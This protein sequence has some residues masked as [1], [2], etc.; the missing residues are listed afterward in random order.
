V[1]D[2]Q[3]KRILVMFCG[4][5]LTMVHRPDGSYGTPD[6]P[7]RAMR[8]I[9]DLEPRLPDEVAR[10]EARFVANIDSTNVEPDHWVKMIGTIADSYEDYDGFVITHG[11]DTMAYTASALSVAIADLGKP[12]VITGAQI[13]SER[14]DSDAQRN[15]VNAV[16]VA[17]LDLAGV[18]LVF[19][20]EII[21][22]RKATKVSES[23]LNAFETVN[24]RVFGEIRTDIRFTGPV[25]ARH[26]RRPDFRPTFDPAV[27]VA[28]IVP[29]FLPGQISALIACGA[30][31]I[32]VRG[33][34]VGNVPTRLL[35]EIEAAIGGG[36]PVVV[37]TQCVEGST[38]MEVYEVGRSVLT[39]GAIQ[40]RDFS[41]EY[42]V[43]RAMWVLGQGRIPT[44]E[45]FA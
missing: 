11:T 27:A 30:K 20:E 28:T 35:P 22:G 15:F 36:V 3:L 32:V 38:D 25:P 41:L 42:T 21:E 39:A 43:T 19:D 9:L 31:A 29:G 17:T 6:D 4:G 7:D 14:I 44:A 40:G 24:D 18:Y 5:T 23:K 12:V 1:A 37:A 13:P 8:A 45:D 10:L 33:Y 2:A 26:D 16:R 34:G